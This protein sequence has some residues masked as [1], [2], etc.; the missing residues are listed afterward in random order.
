MYRCALINSV[1]LWVLV[2]VCQH[3]KA[4]STALLTEAS[5]IFK[6]SFFYNFHRFLDSLSL[7]WSNFHCN[8]VCDRFCSGFL[9]ATWVSWFSFVPGCRLFFV[10]FF[11]CTYVS[12][13]FPAPPL[14][15]LQVILRRFAFAC[16]CF[17]CRCRFWLWRCLA[18]FWRCLLLVVFNFCGGATFFS[19][20]I[21]LL[22]LDECFRRC[23][24]F[25]WFIHTRCRIML[26]HS[27]GQTL[28]YICLE[29][30]V[31]HQ[32]SSRLAWPVVFSNA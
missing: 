13:C 5:E 8:S 4:W 18:R 11:S 26:F 1:Q 2:W 19:N 12:F 25:L 14:E 6:H 20:T 22:N 27:F 28:P 32:F 16:F 17:A 7:A 10:V 9:P 31:F 23:A 29:L 21:F 30:F 15:F 24:V 3:R